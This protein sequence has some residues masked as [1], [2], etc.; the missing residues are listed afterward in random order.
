MASLAQVLEEI[1]IYIRA[2]YPILYVVTWEEE[3]AERLLKQVAADLSKAILIWSHTEG[4]RGKPSSKG[5]DVV[6]SLN[7]VH[8]SDENALFVFKDFH[9]FM[10]EGIVVRR[11]RD[12]AAGLKKSYKTL[13][14]LSPILKVPPELEKDITVIDLPL[15]DQDDLRHA[16][17]GFLESMKGRIEI[18][19]TADLRERAVKASLGFTI[20]QAENVFARAIVSDRKFSP[21]DLALIIREKQQIVRKSGFLEYYDT[22]EG[23]DQVGGLENLKEW[24]RNRSHAFSD[25]AREYG[26]PDPKG[27]LLLGVQG[28]GKSLTAKAIASLW[29]LPLL[30]FDVGTVFGSFIGQTEEN[31]RKALRLAEAISPTVLW[32]DEIEKGFAGVRSGGRTDA[33]VSARVFGTFLTWLQ[34]KKK[35]VFV[36]ATANNVKDLPPEFLRKG[37]FDE[38]FFVDLPTREERERILAI[39]LEKRGRERGRFDLAQL[40]R[41][42][43]GFSGAELEEAIV[44]AMYRAFP[45]DRDIEGKDI[46]QALKETVPL[47]VLL[48][49]EVEALRSWATQRARPAS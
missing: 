27:L 3:R 18:R 29:R 40:S 21:D 41:D 8:S 11:L 44:S 26:L 36:V 13:V 23:L 42:S 33:G 1:R 22:H 4:F 19:M 45:E 25:R 7:Q 31:M 32:M 2:R 34:E 17:D 38:I 9:P 37:R 5:Y 15:P 6:D 28:C 43:D 14:I 20:C 35:P 49:E 10:E 46:G 30:R 12:I 47:S 16:L 24:L 48:R 39:H